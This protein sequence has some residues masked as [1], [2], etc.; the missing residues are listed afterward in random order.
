MDYHQN[1]IVN[2]YN[3]Y[4]SYTILR[5][6]HSTYFCGVGEILCFKL[7]YDLL[8]KVNIYK[9]NPAAYVLLVVRSLIEF[10]PCGVLL[11][12]G[13]VNEKLLLTTHCE[14]RLWVLGEKVQ[15]IYIF[16]LLTRFDDTQ[17]CRIIFIGWER[18]GFI[19]V[20]EYNVLFCSGFSTEVVFN[21]TGSLPQ[22]SLP[23]R[24]VQA[25]PFWVTLEWTR[26]NS[27]STEDVVTYTLEMQDE[28]KVWAL[29][30]ELWLSVVIISTENRFF[31]VLYTGCHIS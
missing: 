9:Y 23:P 26:P 30:Q 7:F 13:A 4:F 18:M 17:I 15:T 29:V 12:N 11:F 16:V 21:T 14:W 28:T 27:C 24:L 5:F 2:E 6:R 25:C 8:Q 31:S 1:I 19:T 3:I 10:W 20:Y 22:T